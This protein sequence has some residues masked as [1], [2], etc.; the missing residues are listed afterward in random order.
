MDY[1]EK[2]KFKR[3][4]HQCPKCNRNIAERRGN[5]L[6]FLHYSD[7]KRDQVK[8]EVNHDAGGR[9]EVE[10]PCGGKLIITQ[11]TLSMEYAIKKKVEKRPRKKKG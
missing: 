3:E 6:Y 8:V 7:G 11:K 4:I 10:C 5:Q 1:H 2:E 9:V